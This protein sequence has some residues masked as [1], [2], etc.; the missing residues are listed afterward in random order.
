MQ[1]RKITTP[2]V[3]V[4]AFFGIQLLRQPYSSLDLPSLNELS[5]RG[6]V[7]STLGLPVEQR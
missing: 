5:R 6:E 3:S 4:A 7:G 2:S 1:S